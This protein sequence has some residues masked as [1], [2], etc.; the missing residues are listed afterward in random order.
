MNKLMIKTLEKARILA[1]NAY[2]NAENRHDNPNGEEYMDISQWEIMNESKELIQEID[3][4]IKYLTS[5]VTSTAT[6]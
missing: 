1:E 3:K 4:I 5:Y 6:E 2:D